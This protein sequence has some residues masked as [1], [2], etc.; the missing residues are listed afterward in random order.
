MARCCTP[1]PGERIV[2]IR[3]DDGGITVHTI[4]CD[5]LAEEDQ[6]QHRWLDLQWRNQE[7]EETS[8]ITRI[9]A[10]IQNGV[11]VLSEVAG[12]VARYGISIASIRLQNRSKEFVELLMDVE[13]KD[14]RQ[15]SQALAGI[16]AAPSVI[17]A[18]RTGSDS[19][20]EL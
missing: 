10:T 20:E 7:D 19:D 5:T 2:G 9:S 17:S 6:S 14:A 4:Y 18:E 11:G 15:L 3:E 13:V 16:R 8:A 1:L 12:I